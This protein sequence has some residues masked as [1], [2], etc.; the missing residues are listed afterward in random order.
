MK[1]W[2]S[3]QGENFKG[4]WEE[5]FF[6]PIE[7]VICTLIACGLSVCRLIFGS[8]I[9]YK[10]CSENHVQVKVPN[11]TWNISPSFCSSSVSNYLEE[12]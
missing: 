8:C 1:P 3:G 10:D 6:V 4:L 2:G 9:R 7:D 5:G 12:N 11:Y